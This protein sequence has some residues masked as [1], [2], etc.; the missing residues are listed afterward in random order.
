MNTKGNTPETQHLRLLAAHSSTP[1]GTKKD[2]PP[3]TPPLPPQSKN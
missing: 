2:E 1:D 3:E